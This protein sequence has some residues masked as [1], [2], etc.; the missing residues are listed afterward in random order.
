MSSQRASVVLAFPCA[1]ERHA[2]HAADVRAL[3]QG[4]FIYEPSADAQAAGRLWRLEAASLDGMVTGRELLLARPDRRGRVSACGLAML[5]VTQIDARRMWVVDHLVREE[6]APA[7][8]RWRERR[9]DE[10]RFAFDMARAE[11]E[12]MATS[13][14]NGSQQELAD[15]LLG[16]CANEGDDAAAKL[17][18]AR[19]AADEAAAARRIVPAGSGSSGRAEQRPPRGVV[20][21]TA[22]QVCRYR[23]MRCAGCGEAFERGERMKGGGF[24]FVH[25]AR[26]CA[27]SAARALLH[28]A[29]RQQGVQ[30]RPF[31][32]V[33]CA[34]ADEAR[35]CSVA[36]KLEREYALGD[37]RAAMSAGGLLLP[38]H[39]RS[40]FIDFVKWLASGDAGRA[41]SVE[42][43][44]IAA[45][46]FS[47]ETRLEDWSADREIA[48][49]LEQLKEQAA[50]AS[51]DE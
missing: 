6:R 27:E 10:R 18:L 43:V 7:R 29:D 32:C 45:R 11:L 26:R 3:A 41:S 16:E 49:L 17:A 34:T 1:A 15:A 19:A 5:G 14:P 48:A 36:A 39:D 23:G 22:V 33:A 35:A 50:V 21:A 51:K 28:E 4:S 25:D 8:Q 20:N 31:G 38:R 2:R 47:A 44:A 30:G 37:G 12:V 40:T 42:Q 9:W 46:M 24:A 13:K